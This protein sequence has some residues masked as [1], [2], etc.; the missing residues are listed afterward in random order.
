MKVALAGVASGEPDGSGEGSSRA[1]CS[2]GGG[3]NS[4][5][6]V[7]RGGGSSGSDGGDTCA[8]ANGRGGAGG[9]ESSGGEALGARLGGG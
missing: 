8:D 4:R 5:S 9:L 2:D 7:E 1:S 6:G 3:C